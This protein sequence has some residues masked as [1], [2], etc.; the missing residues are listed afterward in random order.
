MPL[1]RRSTTTTTRG[2]AAPWTRLTWPVARTTAAAAPAAAPTHAIQVHSSAPGTALSLLYMAAHDD[3]ML[4]S[5]VGFSTVGALHGQEDGAER[6]AAI[7][8]HRAT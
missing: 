7:G 5:F 8:P 3:A 4:G 1:T 2:A 6:P